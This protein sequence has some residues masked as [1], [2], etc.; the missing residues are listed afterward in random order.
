[1]DIGLLTPLHISISERR[2]EM[3]LLIISLSPKIDIDNDAGKTALE[4]AVD[5][6]SYRITRHLLLN[7]VKRQTDTKSLIDIQKKCEDKDIHKLLV[8]FMQTNSKST[9][10]SPKWFLLLIFTLILKGSFLWLPMIKTSLISNLLQD[11]LVFSVV[12][13]LLGQCTFALLL[14]CSLSSPGI[15]KKSSTLTLFV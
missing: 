12:P 13:F 5:L 6:G 14:V 11:F 3:A 2:E 1:M 8:N 10:A 7:K 4:L 15:E 9:T